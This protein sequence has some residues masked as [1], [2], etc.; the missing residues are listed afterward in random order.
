MSQQAQSNPKRKTFRQRRRGKSQQQSNK[1]NNSK[2]NDE[3]KSSTIDST[4]SN[5]ES[6]PEV[7]EQKF[8][9]DLDY[10][11]TN[12][13]PESLHSHSQYETVYV[14]TG[15]FTEVAI[16]VQHEDDE[17]NN[18]NR[19]QHRPRN[20]RN[21]TVAD[22][23]D[24]LDDLDFSDDEEDDFVHVDAEIVEEEI[25]IEDS[26]Q[27]NNRNKNKPNNV[28]LDAAFPK[29]DGKNKRTFKERKSAPPSSSESKSSFRNKAKQPRVKTKGSKAINFDPTID[30]KNSEGRI[31]TDNSEDLVIPFEITK[32]EKIKEGPQFDR[33]KQRRRERRERI[34]LRKQAELD[35]KA[36]DDSSNGDRVQS[37]PIESSSD[38]STKEVNK[39][40]SKSE[41]KV[42]PRGPKVP[43]QENQE[44]QGEKSNSTTNDSQVG[45]KHSAE[46]NNQDG[47]ENQKI[48]SIMRDNQKGS[49]QSNDQSRKSHLEKKSSLKEIFPEVH[50]LRYEP[51]EMEAVENNKVHPSVQLLNE[52]SSKTQTKEATSQSF[53]KAP[54]NSASDKSTNRFGITLKSTNTTNRFNHLPEIQPIRTIIGV[55]HSQILNSDLSDVKIKTILNSSSTSKYVNNVKNFIIKYQNDPK[56]E[57]N[58]KSFIL[59]CINIALYEAQGVNKTQSI[60][61]SV[62]EIFSTYQELNLENTKTTITKSERMKHQNQLDYSFLGFIGY[63]LIWAYVL[64]I[65]QNQEEDNFINQFNLQDQINVSLIKSKIGGFHLWDKLNKNS[66]INSKRWK[67]IIK[68]RNT[69]PYEEDQFLIILRFFK[70]GDIP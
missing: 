68:F 16:G 56:F 64:Q 5:G 22:V 58:K 10:L 1:P 2:R 42:R 52:Q 61:P 51:T 26:G 25:I 46:G 6:T 59:L 53:P 66:S 60:F 40:E 23:I 48:M 44:N 28:D 17:D 57:E 45:H 62:V 30:D 15:N 12:Q 70:I 4:T 63:I 27:K 20:R 69:F 11:L 54:T 24:G 35:L 47:P 29:Y 38:S 8:Q 31:D 9:N 13:D 18:N 37:N 32:Q 36:S 50:S 65:N 3:H 34:R 19:Q 41:N 67:H 55:S 14:P 33:Q 49:I 43:N 21:F 39:V 7:V